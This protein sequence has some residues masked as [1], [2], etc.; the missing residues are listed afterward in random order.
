MV[1]MALQADG[2]WLRSDIIWAKPNPMPESVKDRPTKA[3][4]Y[5]FLLTKQARYY[6]DAES[7]ST[8][9]IT[10]GRVGGFAGDKNQSVGIG[11]Q[12]SGNQIPENDANYRRPERTNART[13]L[14]IATQ[15]FPEA[16]FATFPEKLV[17]P[18]IKAGTKPKDTVL[19]PFA[20]SGT[21]GVVSLKLGRSFIGIELQPDYV[22]MAEKRIGNVM[23]L[24]DGMG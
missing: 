11:R 12:P 1:A 16:H 22:K 4:E 3:H 6:Y 24:F 2:W 8:P 5:V 23:P 9:A 21:V 15:P 10:A 20:G 18:C 13:V 17:E 14:T 19:D 7:I